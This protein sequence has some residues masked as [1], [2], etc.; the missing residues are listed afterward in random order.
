[1]SSVNKNDP[2]P[3]VMGSNQHGVTKTKE[4]G[5]KH[6]SLY[7]CALCLVTVR[8]VLIDL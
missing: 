7:T 6:N 2:Y 5:Q 8:D 4:S 1:M 3:L